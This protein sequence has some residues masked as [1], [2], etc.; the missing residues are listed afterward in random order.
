MK[1]LIVILNAGIW[2]ILIESVNM[3]LRL[4]NASKITNFCRWKAIIL[5]LLYTNDVSSIFL[6]KVAFTSW[7][8][9]TYNRAW[10][11]NFK[12]CLPLLSHC[13]QLN[14]VTDTC[15]QLH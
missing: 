15:W 7:N 6:P 14:T 10:I 11:R 8:N 9:A 1:V 13:L 12:T 5:Q 2:K 3:N 4:H